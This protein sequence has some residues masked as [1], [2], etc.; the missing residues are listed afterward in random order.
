M[1][2]LFAH[3]LL[4]PALATAS[5]PAPAPAL[6]RPPVV[7][8]AA[9]PSAGPGLLLP[10]PAEGLDGSPPTA[11]ADLS[12]DEVFEAAA[13]ALEKVDTL[14]AGF[15]MLSPSGEESSGKIY[16]DRP[17]RLRFDYADPDPTDESE[18][19]L[20]V[21][22]GGVVY[23][24]EPDRDSSES[25]PVRETPLQF[26][27]SKRLD[28]EAAE[29]AEVFRFDDGVT[30][31]VRPTDDQLQGSL[32]L[33]FAAETMQLTGWSVFS[34]SGDVT[35]VTLNDIEMGKRLPG[36]LFRVPEARGLGLGDDF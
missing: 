4:G 13:A 7:Q 30:V 6:A 26:L 34:P 31:F 22:T 19:M 16:L 15:V 24:D 11:F 18:P 10:A 27:L 29:L 2:P 17:G 21:A 36:R 28:R 33:T 8:E 14:E 32:G 23:I 9:L 3:I 1:I 35:Q 25:Y 20:I 5:V 12:D